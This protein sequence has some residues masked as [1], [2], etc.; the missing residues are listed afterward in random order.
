MHVHHHHRGY[1][2]KRLGNDVGLLLFPHNSEKTRKHHYL[3]AFIT[4]AGERCQRKKGTLSIPDE[5]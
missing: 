3:T 2:G 4:L 5:N 1:V